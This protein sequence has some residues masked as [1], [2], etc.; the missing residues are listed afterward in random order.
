[1]RRDVRWQHGAAVTQGETLTPC[2][3][4]R[5]GRLEGVMSFQV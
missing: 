3:E 1:M 4:L 2:V 5:R